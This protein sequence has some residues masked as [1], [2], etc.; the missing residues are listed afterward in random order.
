[1][2]FQKA[3]ASI[4]RSIR[5]VSLFRDWQRARGSRELPDI[6]DFT[7]NE[8]AGDSADILITEVVRRG[9]ALSYLCRSAGER[10]EQLY[11]VSMSARPLD[12]CL[13]RAMAN[14]ARP[15]WDACIQH[16]LPMYCILPL[17]DLNGCPVTVEQIFLPYSRGGDTADFMLGALHAWSTEGRFASQGLLRNVAK[18]PVHWA[19]IIDPAQTRAPPTR[20]AGNQDTGNQDLA[21]QDLA[22]QAVGNDD[23]EFDSGLPAPSPAR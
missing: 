1:M 13:D 3:H 15:I 11:D 16:R 10:V 5:Q 7:P 19:V 12:D 20:D 6:A 18:V 8:R 4:V 9:G 14:A 21:N 2:Y 22:N 17:S 23:V